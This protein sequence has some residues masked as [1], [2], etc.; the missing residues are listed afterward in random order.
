MLTI[1]AYLCD[2]GHCSYPHQS[3][4]LFHVT[5][6]SAVEWSYMPPKNLG[7]YM[8]GGIVLGFFPWKIQTR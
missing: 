6:V 3:S 1:S 7:I 5:K 4:H 2:L 8:Q